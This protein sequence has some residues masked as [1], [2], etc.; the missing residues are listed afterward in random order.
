MV[1]AWGKLPEKERAKAM[2]DMVR[3][4]PPAYQQMIEDYFRR[5]ASSPNQP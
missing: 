4:M 1:E 2:T 3:S 5:S